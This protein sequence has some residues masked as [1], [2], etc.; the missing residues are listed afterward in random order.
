MKPTGQ[1][2]LQLIAALGGFG[3]AGFYA[4]ACRRHDLRTMLAACVAAAALTGAGFIFYTSV[5]N[6]R[7][8]SALGGFGGTLLE[9]ALMDLAVRA[10]PAGAE[11]MGFALMMSARNVCALGADWIGST[12]LDKHY[13]DF[14]GMVL[15]G[16]G[17]TLVAAPMAFLL[18][19]HLTRRKDAEIYEEFPEPETMVQE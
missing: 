2:F 19:H 14:N 7:I 12:L 16:A 3:A 18:P 4:W 15:L 9:L 13:F 11:G 1:G 8:L 6:A 10:T 17:W 5:D